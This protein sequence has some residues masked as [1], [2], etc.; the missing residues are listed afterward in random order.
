MSV[1]P[2]PLNLELSAPRGEAAQE[3]ARLVAGRRELVGRLDQI[4]Q[5]QRQASEEVARLS[6]ELPIWSGRRQAPSKSL[7]PTERTSCGYTSSVEPSR[8]A[9]FITMN[10][11]RLAVGLNTSEA[12]R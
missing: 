8:V 6:A 9:R 3:L 10:E 7:P 1:A 5:Q 2:R 12:R 11:Y 4:D